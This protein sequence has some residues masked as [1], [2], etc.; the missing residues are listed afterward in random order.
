[1]YPEIK[2]L[3]DWIL[4]FVFLSI[5]IWPFMLITIISVVTDKIYS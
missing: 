5:P 3:T 4:M 1:M 2:T